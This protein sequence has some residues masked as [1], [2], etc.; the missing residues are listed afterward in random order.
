MFEFD[1]VVKPVATAWTEKYRPKNMK[2]IILPKRYTTY[3]NTLINDGATSIIMHSVSPGSGKTTMAKAFC[4]DA[5]LSAMYINTSLHRGIDTLRS[6][7]L[8]YA[9]SRSIDGRKKA[10]IF[11]EF[12]G[13]TR[14]LQNALKASIEEVGEYCRFIFTA[15]NI[16]NIIEPLISRSEVMNFDYTDS[17][18]AEMVPKIVKRLSGIAEKEGVSF[19]DGVMGRIADMFFP[20]IRSMINTV[21]K[22]SK[23]FG[24]IDNQ[25]FDKLTGYDSLEKSI[26]GLDLVGARTIIL[27]NGYKF[28]NLYR[29]MYDSIIPQS[30]RDS[31]CDLYKLTAEYFDMSTRSK[32]QEIT[33][34]GYLS[35]FMTYL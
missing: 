13:A 18:K 29:Y 32:D 10:V 34:I 33:F 11:D 20:D 23:E 14:E 21:S 8:N 1:D 15:N 27:E 16:N 2:S 25:I 5:N 12:D 35:E 7:V 30:P 9:M 26:M 28:E 24:R 19:E 31:R 3:F 22:Y 4:N 6:D 17:D